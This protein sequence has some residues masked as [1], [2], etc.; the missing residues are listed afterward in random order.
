MRLLIVD[1]QGVALDY[2]LRCR[3]AGHEV[4]HF[5]PQSEKTKHIGRGLVDVVDDLPKWLFW[6]NIIFNADNIKY[7][8]EMERARE[9]KITVIS[10]TEETAEW[11]TKRSV[12][13]LV[14]RRAGILVP[15]YTEF[16][17]YDKAIDFVKQH[18][19]RFVSKPSNSDDKALS[20]VAESPEDMVYMLERWKR[21]SKLKSSFMLQEFI[22]GT[23]MAVG[24]W[25]GKNG[26]ANSAWC[27]NFEFKKL[28]VGNLGVATGEQG[29]VLRYVSASKLAKKV[30]LPLTSQLQQAGYVGYIDVNCI[31]DDDGHPWPLEFTTRFGWPTFQIQ[32]E[33]HE[34]DP[35]T[36]LYDLATGTDPQIFRHDLIALGAVL[37]IPDYPYSHLTR[38]EVIGVPIY[39]ITPSLRPHIHLCEAM[40]GNAPDRQ[41]EKIVTKTMPVTAGDYVLIA[42]SCGSSVREARERVYARLKRLSVPNSPMWRTDIGMRLRHELPKIQE[43]GFA[44]GMQY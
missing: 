12:G 43:H 42:S 37:S 10:A 36:W 39:G 41:G 27:E 28:C 35:L 22:Q 19:V 31:I 34:G 30:L 15:A 6:P 23:E 33:L 11:E 3:A 16:D 38:K 40:L 2:A 7:L 44:T 4:K 29:T 26:W 9:A 21:A 8:R 18:M 5:I 32:Q 24:G 17:N 13:Q 20:Y 25:F 14:F 1:P